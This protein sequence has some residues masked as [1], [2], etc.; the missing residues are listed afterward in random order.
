MSDAGF[1]HAIYGHWYSNHWPQKNIGP[2]GSDQNDD[3]SSI[4]S[5]VPNWKPSEG[6]WAIEDDPENNHRV[7]TRTSERPVFGKFYER[8]ANSSSVDKPNLQGRGPWL[9]GMLKERWRPETGLEREQ[10]IGRQIAEMERWRDRR[11]QKA[12]KIDLQKKLSKIPQM[13]PDG[14]FDRETVGTLFLYWAFEAVGVFYSK[15]LADRDREFVVDRPRSDYDK[16][17]DFE[18]FSEAAKVAFLLAK[19]FESR[20]EEDHCHYI[21]KIRNGTTAKDQRQRQNLEDRLWLAT[22]LHV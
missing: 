4:A 17:A 14:F 11:Y 3:L 21:V 2:D 19:G 7:V 6:F 20:Y 22:E 10:R 18:K 8:N 1:V 16:E 5:L 15:F 13:T 12:D 9:F